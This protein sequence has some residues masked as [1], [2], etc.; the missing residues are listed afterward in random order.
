MQACDA[1]PADTMLNNYIAYLSHMRKRAANKA[2]TDSIGETAFL[3]L[4]FPGTNGF[5][6]PEAMGLEFD[7]SVHLDPK[8][9]D[10]RSSND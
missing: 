4:R 6:M 10:L 1:Q 2:F 9:C 7:D 8:T 3:L 5:I